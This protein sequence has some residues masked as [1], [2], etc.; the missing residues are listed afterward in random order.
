MARLSTCKGCGKE[1]Q[2]NEKKMIGSKSYCANC[3]AR[4]ERDSIEYKQLIEFVCKNYE[5]DA[6]TGFMLKQIKEFRNDYNYPYSAITYTLWYCKEILQKEL[7][8]NYG[9]ALVKYYYEEA[10]DYYTQQSRIIDHMK[11][12]SDSDI[13]TKVVKGTVINS[14]RNNNSLLDLSNLLKDGE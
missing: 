6:P 12:I 7:Q 3:Y 5:I 10:K 9:L 11:S 2:P 1:L 13:K 14:N 8:V 4:A